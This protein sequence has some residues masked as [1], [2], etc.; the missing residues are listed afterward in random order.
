MGAGGVGVVLYI[1]GKKNLLWVLYTRDEGLG[2]EYGVGEVWSWFGDIKL[3]E[4]RLRTGLSATWVLAKCG[5][6]GVASRHR[7][8]GCR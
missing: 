3:L 5:V 4:C 7:E 8:A 1:W 2:V 6:R